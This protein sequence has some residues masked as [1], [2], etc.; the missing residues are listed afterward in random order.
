MFTGIGF[1]STLNKNRYQAPGE[2]QPPEDKSYL[3]ETYAGGKFSISLRRIHPT[4]SGNIL[5]VRNDSNIE[6]SFGL[7]ND[8]IDTEGILNHIGNGEGYVVEWYGINETGTVIKFNQPNAANQPKIATAGAIITENGKPAIKFDG[9]NTYLSHD[10]SSGQTN[11]YWD[12]LYDTN[13]SFVQAVY[14]SNSTS[15]QTIMGNLISLSINAFILILNYQN[16]GGIEIQSGK[17]S[18]MN[19]SDNISGNNINSNTQTIFTGHID[20]DNPV[21]ED[22]SIMQLNGESEI[23]NNTYTNPPVSGSAARRMGIG[24]FNG[25]LISR[26][27][28]GTIQEI[29]IWSADHYANK[30][31]IITEINNY[32]SIF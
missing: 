19:G 27:F 20:N 1:K 10:T 15:G 30:D 4:Y 24:A 25:D 22:R 18:T 32:Y 23:K 16:T 28:S 13:P 12:F 17:L 6:A 3:F 31:A 21:A 5:T 11:E 8:V 26:V 9:V 29:N 14:T 2:V 7:V